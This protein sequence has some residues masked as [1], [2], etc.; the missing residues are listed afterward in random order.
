PP[1]PSTSSCWTASTS[2]PSRSLRTR[3]RSATGARAPR[4]CGGCCPRSPTRRRRCRCTTSPPPVTPETA[5]LSLLRWRR[6]ARSADERLLVRLH[7]RR[8]DVQHARR[9]SPID[10]RV[11]RRFRGLPRRRGRH[12][13]GGA[14]MT[15]LDFTLPDDTLAAAIKRMFGHLPPRQHQWDEV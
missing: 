4:R 10:R 5:P 6:C 7:V 11:C 3:C 15:A 8:P 1:S 12:L 14:R 13:L 2:P 9:G